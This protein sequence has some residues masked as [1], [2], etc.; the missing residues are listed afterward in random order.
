[1]PFIELE[2][3]LPAE[4]L[5]ADLPAK[6]CSEAAT[7]LGKPVERVNVTVRSGLQMVVGGSAAPCAQLNVASIGVVGSAEQN[8]GHSSRFFDFLTRQLALSPDRILIRF[9]PLEPW[10]IGK[11]GTVM[12]FL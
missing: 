3:S 10:Q 4:R 9:Y 8:K 11:N 2:T 1:M 7:I 6:L 5:P 12:T